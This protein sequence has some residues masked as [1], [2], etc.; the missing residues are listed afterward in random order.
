MARVYRHEIARSGTVPSAAGGLNVHLSCPVA[1]ADVP[2]W[3][4]IVA[5]V[6][7][8]LVIISDHF[9]QGQ[10]GAL[11]TV[12]FVSDRAVDLPLPAHPFWPSQLSTCRTRQRTIRCRGAPT[13]P[14]LWRIAWIV[15][16]RRYRGNVGTGHG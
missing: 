12:R 15:T 13:S 14:A 4:L 2:C 9:E 10:S 5:V 6:K 7:A 8:R 3:T 11:A 16:R 1:I